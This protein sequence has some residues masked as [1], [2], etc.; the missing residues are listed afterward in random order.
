M[1]EVGDVVFLRTNTRDDYIGRVAE[2]NGPFSMTLDQCSWVADSGLYSDFRRNGRSESME[3]EYVG[4][5]EVFFSVSSVG[6]WPFEL[7]TESIR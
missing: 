1:V 7:P 2:I 6:P 5:G 4:D 3:Y